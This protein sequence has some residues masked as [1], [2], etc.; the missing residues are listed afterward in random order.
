[1]GK[2]GSS[3]TFLVFGTDQLLYVSATFHIVY[4]HLNPSTHFLSL[5]IPGLAPPRTAQNLLARGVGRVLALIAE[6]DIFKGG[7][8]VERKRQPDGSP[9]STSRISAG[10]LAYSHYCSLRLTTS[11]VNLHPTP[12]T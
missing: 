5:Y 2:Q 1:M 10:A 4:V 9:N 11:V 6:N 8:L 12:W 7:W 3:Y